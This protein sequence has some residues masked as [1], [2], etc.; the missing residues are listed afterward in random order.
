MGRTGSAPETVK[1][2]GAVI[3]TSLVGTAIFVVI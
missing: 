3:T 1:G 2:L